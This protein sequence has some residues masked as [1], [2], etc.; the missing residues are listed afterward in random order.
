[1]EEI[2]EMVQCQDL[3][4]SVVLSGGYDLKGFGD[5]LVPEDASGIEE[6]SC[7]PRQ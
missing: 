3:F 4:F 1:M 2:W 7:L 6:N 5:Q